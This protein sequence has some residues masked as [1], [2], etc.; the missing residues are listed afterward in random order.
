[1]DDFT[2]RSIREREDDSDSADPELKRIKTEAVQVPVLSTDV[3]VLDNVEAAAPGDFIRRKGK[4]SSRRRDA[5]GYANSRRGKEKSGKNAGRRRGNC[6]SEPL[7]E[8]EGSSQL[9]AEQAAKAPRL[10]KRQCALLIGFCGTGCNGMQMYVRLS[11]IYD[12]DCFYCLYLFGNAVSQ[13]FERSKA[14]SLR[15][16]LKLVLCRKTTLMIQA[17]YLP[18]RLVC[19][20]LVIITYPQGQSWSSCQNR[21]WS[22]RCRKCGVYQNDHRCTRHT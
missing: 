14:Y 21:R 4:S 2:P 22:S 5:A 20:K 1:M 3:P 9:Q 15:L 6:Q 11:R 13:T 16:W 19:P 17:R 7:Q 12:H 10:P 8:A 18:N